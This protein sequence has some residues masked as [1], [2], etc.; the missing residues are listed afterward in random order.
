MTMSVKRVL[1]VA[2]KWW[3]ADPLCAVL[4]HDR[5]RP[6]SFK[7]FAFP[8]FPVLRSSAPDRDAPAPPDPPVVP[9]LC[10]DCR[11]ARIEVWCIEELMNPAQ[12]SSAT[13]EKARVLPQAFKAGKPPDL[14]LAFGTAG[15]REG[16]TANGSVVIGRRTFVHDPFPPS[17]DHQGKWVPPK[18]DIVIES[19]L[20]ASSLRSVNEQSRFAAE[21]R[22]LRPPIAPAEPPLV[23]VGN[24]F[25]SVGVVNITN[26]DDY[27]W[28]DRQ[29]TEACNRSHPG[30][31]F[32]EN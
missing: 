2:N 13:S 27:L 29:A 17:V 8:R 1:I 12:S 30:G 32:L 19:S 31:I 5:A 10:F 11:D 28:A 15:S 23:L 16:V 22:L 3:E 20:P 9:R 26:Y 21:A 4:I 6:P 14:V 18:P 25:I 7:N 24:G